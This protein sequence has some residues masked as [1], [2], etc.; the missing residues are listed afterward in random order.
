MTDD[1]YWRWVG[2]AAG[3]AVGAFALGFAALVSIPVGGFLLLASLVLTIAW[4]V[5]LYRM[6]RAYRWR[7]WTAAATLPVALFWPAAAVVIGSIMANSAYW[8]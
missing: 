8:N 1:A 2:W 4:G 5:V 3:L 7:A 6:V